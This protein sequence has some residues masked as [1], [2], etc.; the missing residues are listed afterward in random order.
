MISQSTMPKKARKRQPDEPVLATFMIPYEKWQEFQRLARNQ[1]TTAS[2][3]LVAFVESYLVGEND[4]SVE[5]EVA[6]ENE[7]ID[8]ERERQWKAEIEEQLKAKIEQDL[9]A[10]IDDAIA[11]HTR[12]LTEELTAL[13]TLV[14]QLMQRLETAEDLVTQEKPKTLYPSDIIDVEVVGIDVLEEE[15]DNGIGLTQKALCEEFGI[16]PTSIIRNAKVRGLS[17]SDYLHQLTGW[18]YYNGKYY[19]PDLK[20][21]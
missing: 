10:Y 20:F 13:Q 5:A 18:N 6:A 7:A 8:L 17:S 3:T 14:S 15:S 11:F 4:K 2:A 12:Q 19:P 9:K 21:S 1:G 16:N